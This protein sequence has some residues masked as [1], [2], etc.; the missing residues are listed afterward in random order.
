MKIRV[1]MAAALLAAA[2]TPAGLAQPAEESHYAPQW[3]TPWSYAAGPRGPEHWGELDPQYATCGHGKAQSPID[4]R[5]AQRADLP[6]LRFEYHRR[7]V[8]Y[9]TNNGAAIRVNYH[10][11]PGSG[12]FLQ[13]GTRR[14]QLTQFHFH[15]PSEETIAGKR[16]AMVLHL[17]HRADD[18][19][20]AGVAVLLTAGRPN[21]ALA[22][23]W[24]H[25]PSS[26]GQVAVPGLELDLRQLLPQ[27][28]GYY[29]Y[30]GSQTAPPCNEGVRWFVLKNP[31]EVSAQQIAAYA[32]L[33]PHDA[34]PLQ[35]RNGRSIQVSE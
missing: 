5:D 13:V 29:T 9:L 21:A 25:M 16:Y 10:D 31:L 11:A 30:L 4:I 26:E 23:L 7:A 34:R 15:R 20:V 6:P 2:L 24:Q 33:F 19:E 8:G 28:R 32:Q 3:R 17:M 12:D 35:P 22:L 18:G 1:A 27:Q 14:Y